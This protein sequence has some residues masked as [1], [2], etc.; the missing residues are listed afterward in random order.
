MDLEFWIYE[1][2]LGLIFV[3]FNISLIN[4]SLK[5]LAQRRSKR[6]TEVKKTPM[7]PFSQEG[8]YEYK[9]DNHKK[10]VIP[11]VRILCSPI[12]K[13]YCT[14]SKINKF[15]IDLFKLRIHEDDGTS[16]RLGKKCPL[17][18]NARVISIKMNGFKHGKELHEFEPID[19]AAPGSSYEFQMFGDQKIQA[20]YYVEGGVSYP[21]GY[22]I[23]LSK[24]GLRDE[25]FPLDVIRESWWLALCQGRM[26]RMSQVTSA[27]ME[28]DDGSQG[29][30]LCEELEM[31]QIKRQDPPPSYA[32]T[33][34]IV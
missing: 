28:E 4:E 2:I 15:M 3:G 21:A 32:S 23:Y 1:A 17:P 24:T 6:T 26:R 30:K 22:C 10:H 33:I 12:F 29:G 14:S 27:P 31:E 11:D 34:N 5:Y 25:E 7:I 18:M 13:S 16:T 9:G 19:G 20:T 8:L